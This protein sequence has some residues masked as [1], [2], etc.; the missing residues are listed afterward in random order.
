[1]RAFGWCVGQAQIGYPETAPLKGRLLDD[2]AAL[3]RKVHAMGGSKDQPFVVVADPLNG[4]SEAGLITWTP[5]TS[6]CSR[7]VLVNGGLPTLR[8]LGAYLLV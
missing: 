8:M 1:M 5:R 4:W 2:D 7:A 6:G 3:S